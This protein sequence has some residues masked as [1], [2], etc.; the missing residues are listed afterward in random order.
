MTHYDGKELVATDVPPAK[1]KKKTCY[2]LKVNQVPLTNANIAT[3]VA[4][5]DFGQQPLEHQFPEIS[6]RVISHTRRPHTRA[7]QCLPSP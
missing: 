4:T 3:E 5:G 7:R 2:F 6:R 1:F